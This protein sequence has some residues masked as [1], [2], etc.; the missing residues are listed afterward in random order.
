M[1]HED[2][3]AIGNAGLDQ[4]KIDEEYEN[5]IK[6][7]VENYH[8]SDLYCDATVEHPE[9]KDIKGDEDAIA[10][11]TPWCYQYKLL[12]TRNFLNV[13]RLPQTSYVKLTTT[14]V[15]AC[16]VAFFFWQAGAYEPNNGPNTKHYEQIF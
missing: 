3:S 4:A 6:F 1:E 7:F 13:V 11:V 12:A 15:T 16:F 2:D 8:S 10:V 5:L 14:C 9:V